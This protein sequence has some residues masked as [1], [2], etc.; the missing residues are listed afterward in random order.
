MAQPCF[1]TCPHISQFIALCRSAT[2]QNPPRSASFPLSERE[3]CSRWWGLTAWQRA[4]GLPR[5][6]PR[7]AGGH[8][9]ALGARRARPRCLLSSGGGCRVARDST[10]LL[11]FAGFSTCRRNVLP[12]GGLAVCFS[13]LPR[14]GGQP[15]RQPCHGSPH[16]SWAGEKNRKAG[17]VTKLSPR[18]VAGV[19]LITWEN[20]INPMHC[21]KET[22]VSPFQLDSRQKPNTREG[23]KGAFR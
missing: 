10:P 7:E 14:G 3:L 8:L 4:A 6:R 19:C 12:G 23:S 16:R 2:L 1:Q 5:P 20:K 18:N 21:T 22:T 13:L 17:P 11:S 9:C 15:N